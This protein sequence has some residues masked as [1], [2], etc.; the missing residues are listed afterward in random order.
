MLLVEFII[1]LGKS[2]MQ[3]PFHEFL[4]VPILLLFFLIAIWIVPLLVDN[5]KS[6]EWVR[7]PKTAAQLRTHFFWT[8]FAT[9]VLA[10]LFLNPNAHRSGFERGLRLVIVALWV[11]QS[12][13]A[14]RRW[15]HPR[16]SV[17]VDS[18]PKVISGPGK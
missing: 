15:R 12:I 3:N 16:A 11:L 2:N 7:E 17:D 6:F 18:Q 4:A 8:L 9:G 1:G 10:I 13:R 14:F 5:M